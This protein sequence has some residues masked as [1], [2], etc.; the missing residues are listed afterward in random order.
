MIHDGTGKGTLAGVNDRN[1]LLTST[2][3]KTEMSEVSVK[4]GKAFLMATPSLSVTATLGSMF[5]YKNTSTTDKFHINLLIG[6]WNGGD[7]NHNRAM[8]A[9][10][11]KN[12]GAPTANNTVSAMGNA[13]FSSAI[14]GEGDV[15]YWDGVGTGMTLS[16]AGTAAG[17]LWIKNMEIIETSGSI[18]I[19]PGQSLGVSAQGEEVGKCTFLVTGWYSANE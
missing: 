12:P 10:L 11:Y 5:Y 9:V 15:N 13:N 19:G 1:E 7:T 16:S 6:T 4:D 18:I 2:R 3:T 14:S 8:M 17:F